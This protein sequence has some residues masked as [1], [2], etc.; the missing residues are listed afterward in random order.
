MNER[1]QPYGQSERRELSCAP[2]AGKDSTTRQC[3]RAR[4]RSHPRPSRAVLAS[5]VVGRRRCRVGDGQGGGGGRAAALLPGAR[6]CADVVPP[7][8]YTNV[9]VLFAS[10]CAPLRARERER[11][12]ARG[13]STRA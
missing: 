1:G 4:A 7:E 3:A 2:E 13:G 12:T 10:A 11:R 9:H 6:S 5:S 8:R